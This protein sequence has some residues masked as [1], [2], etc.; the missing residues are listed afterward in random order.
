[1]NDFNL[2]GYLAERKQMVDAALE[3]LFPV[4][5]GLEKSVL[6]ASRYSL[7]AGGKRLRPILCLAAAEVVGGTPESILPAACALEMI[8]TY[9]LIHDD[10][11]AMDNDDFRRGKPTCHKAFGEAIAILAGDALLTEAF[12]FIA[13][14]QMQKDFPADKLLKV[15]GIV[16]KASG[17]RGMVG[18]Q[19]ID[20]ESENQ[21]VDVATVEYMHIHKTGALLSASLEVGALL[22]GGTEEQIAILTRYGQHFGLAFQITDD[23]LDIEGDAALMGKTP[24]SDIA[25]NKK[26]YPVLL[27]MTRSKEAA[28]AHVKGAMEAL[29]NFDEKADPLRAIAQYLLVRKA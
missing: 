24:G 25:K 19:V 11:P 21:A 23:I 28:L 6:E 22:G 20:L 10:L 15:I 14:G 17:Y 5:A 27:G 18:G 7:F 3:R 13:E 4:P 8:H 12:G 2:K 16:V 26:T 1:M 29:S 9:S